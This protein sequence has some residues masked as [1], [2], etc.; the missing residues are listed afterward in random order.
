MSKNLGLSDLKKLKK[1]IDNSSIKRQGIPK[2]GWIDLPCFHLCA[3]VRY[4]E[5]PLGENWYEAFVITNVKVDEK[6]RRQGFFGRFLSAI[7]RMVSEDK[8][9]VA[10]YLE[11]VLE[12]FLTAS[13]KGDGYLEMI[14]SGNCFYK[15][16]A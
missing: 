4:S 8:D 14:H 7:E 16:I 9:L 12:E 11:N 2:N 10:V 5:I 1:A 6:Y 3:Y 15:L 13:L